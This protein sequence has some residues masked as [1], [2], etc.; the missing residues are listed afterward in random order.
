VRTPYTLDGLPVQSPAMQKVVERCHLYAPYR[1]PVVFIGPVGS[2]KTTLAQVLHDASGL[3]GLLVSARG[4]ELGEALCEDKL[5]GRVRGA[6]TGAVAS[7][8]GLLAQA[9]HG[10]LFIDDLARMPLAS[11]GVLLGVIDDRRYRPLGS[12]RESECTCRWLFATTTAPRELVAEGR[13]LPDLKSR[14]GTLIVQVP[15][16]R[17]RREDIVPLARGYAEHFLRNDGY[18]GAVSLDQTVEDLLLRYDWP[19]N[20]REL[21]NAMKRAAIHARDERGVTRILPVHL[22]E[23]IDA[24]VPSPS[25]LSERLTPEIAYRAWLEANGNQSEAARRLGVSRNRLARH[26][27]R[28]FRMRSVDGHVRE[29]AEPAPRMVHLHRGWSTSRSRRSA[30]PPGEGSRM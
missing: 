5:F 17:N 24:Y 7:R 19:E 16:L 6:F 10:T 26:L 2:G 3:P 27:K 18:A 1:E 25:S 29:H 12:D 11:Q 22:P 9:A 8:R 21:R 15:P 4:A 28:Y 30:P 13:M 20:L 23:D 14:L